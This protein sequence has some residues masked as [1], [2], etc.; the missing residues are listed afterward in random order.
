MLIMGE[1]SW[2]LP[3]DIEGLFNL[4]VCA[5]SGKFNEMAVAAAA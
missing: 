2:P 4:D 1:I 3:H 5:A